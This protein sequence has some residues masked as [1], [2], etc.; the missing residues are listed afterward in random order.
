MKQ[1]KDW[2]PS[3]CAPLLRGTFSASLSLFISPTRIEIESEENGGDLGDIINKKLEFKVHVEKVIWGSKIMN[4]VSMRPFTTRVESWSWKC[5][6]YIIKNKREH[7]YVV[8]SLTK[9]AAIDNLERIQRQQS[10][11]RD[12][13]SWTIMKIEKNETIQSRKKKR[14]WKFM[15]GNKLK[16]LK[17][18][19]LDL[20]LHNMEKADLLNLQELCNILKR[21]QTKLFQSWARNLERL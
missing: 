5:S 12:W 17:K 19:D 15:L 18:T 4:D 8:L 21:H 16:E 1:S 14:L 13:N 10:E 3:C 11:L 9:E 2:L 20:K 6:S 7:C